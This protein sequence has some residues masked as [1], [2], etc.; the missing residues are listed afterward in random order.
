M[1]KKI[2]AFLMAACVAATSVPM[3]GAVY[4]AEVRM[5]QE[6]ESTEQETET[7]VTTGETAEKTEA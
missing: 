5:E 3:D 7:V 1:K 6:A 4:A 2:L